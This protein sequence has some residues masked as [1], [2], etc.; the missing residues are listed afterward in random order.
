MGTQLHLL[1]SKYYSE[2]WFCDFLNKLLFILSGY[3]SSVCIWC[4]SKR[5]LSISFP[6]SHI[7]TRQSSYFYFLFCLLSY[8]FGLYLLFGSLPF[9]ETHITRIILC[10]DKHLYSLLWW[11]LSFQWIYHTMRRNKQKSHAWKTFCWHNGDQYFPFAKTFHWYRNESCTRASSPIVPCYL[12]HFPPW[13]EFNLNPIE[14]L[15]VIISFRRLNEKSAR[16]K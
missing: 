3:Q 16:T 2:L 5:S 11:K 13:I 15:L 10:V 14:S 8:I 1:H 9:L 12:W 6:L 7:V 4:T